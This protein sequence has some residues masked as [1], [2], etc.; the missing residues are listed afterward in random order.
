LR[1][2]WSCRTSWSCFNPH[3]VRTPGA[4]RQAHRR[5]RTHPAF[6]SSP[7]A[8]TGCDV[9][10]HGHGSRVLLFQSSPGAN[11]GC[12]AV[13]HRAL[14]VGRVQV[15]ILTRCEHRVRRWKPASAVVTT[16]SFQSS[17]GANT[18][19]DISTGAMLS[20]PASFQSS[21]GANT[22]CDSP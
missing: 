9:I 20:A 16:L 7:G 2:M 21:P 8:N 19:C 3:P 10:E 11:T 14:A 5:P 13:V 1:S 18:G 12:D 6:Q 22:G 17:P 4:T 15:S